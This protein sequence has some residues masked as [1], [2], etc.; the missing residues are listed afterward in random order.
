MSKN[1]NDFND[2]GYTILAEWCQLSGSYQYYIQMQCDM[3]K[4]DGAPRNV[5][6]V[7]MESELR[8]L[9]P[10]EEQFIFRAPSPTRNGGKKWDSSRFRST[11]RW[12]SI[13]R[14]RSSRI[15]N[16]KPRR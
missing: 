10:A 14:A 5:I 9:T 13:E 8:S 11:I 4:E 2:R 16:P 3:A 7:R 1:R 12:H 15:S 6:Y